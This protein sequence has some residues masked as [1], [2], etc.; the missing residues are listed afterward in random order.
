MDGTIMAMAVSESGC[1][2][3]NGDRLFSGLFFCYQNLI[4]AEIIHIHDFK[5]EVFPAARICLCRDTAYFV[6]DESGQGFV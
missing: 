4:D 2:Q 6:R 3:K 5:G 1:K